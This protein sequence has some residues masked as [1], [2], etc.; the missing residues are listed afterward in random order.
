MQLMLSYAAHPSDSD[1]LKKV[2]TTDLE[3]KTLKLW[4]EPKL[5]VIQHHCCF[6]K[7]LCLFFRH[8]RSTFRTEPLG[9][10]RSGTESTA[11]VETT[12][13]V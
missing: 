1:A 7:T 13:S 6:Q 2:C 12:S 5:D 10:I 3:L 4:A 9:A 8:P 11:R